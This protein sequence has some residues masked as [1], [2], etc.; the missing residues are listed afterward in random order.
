MAQRT[1]ELRRSQF[2][3]HILCHRLDGDGIDPEHNCGSGS[4]RGEPIANAVRALPRI[5]LIR[6][7]DGRRGDN[8]ASRGCGCKRGEDL[9]ICAVPVS[10]EVYE[11]V[12]AR[13]RLPAH[14]LSCARFIASEL[15]SGKLQNR[16]NGET[17][18][19]VEVFEA[20]SV[21]SPRLFR[22]EAG[23]SLAK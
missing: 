18:N 1:H 12:S 6:L 4:F 10:I 2:G 23:Q 5:W 16:V 17:E 19:N 13:R 14:G 22:F 11:S 3:L 21:F 8:G 9:S 20:L 15:N 7:A